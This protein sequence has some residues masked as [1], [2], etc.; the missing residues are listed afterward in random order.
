MSP[1]RDDEREFSESIAAIREGSQ[2]AIWTLI[3]RYAPHI[4]RVVRR[5]LDKQTRTCFE[6]V[7]FVQMVWAS[8]FREP[9]RITTFQSAEELIRYLGA[10]ARNKVTDV[11]RQ[12]RAAKN[13]RRREQP[14]EMLDQPPSLHAARPP[15]EI[16]IAREMW[17]R[18]FSQQSE[19]DR[20]MVEL[21]IQGLTFVEIGERLGT[22]ER[23]VRRV[24][25]R[26][27]ASIT[28]ELD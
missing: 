4:E 7:D 17:F 16:A 20:Q 13:D 1:S 12:M 26:M 18:M 9:R 10:M 14:I 15:D 5:R 8:F 25:D 27:L 2:T 19:R 11:T 21:R 3:E 24:L 6:T 23:T 22:N 28:S